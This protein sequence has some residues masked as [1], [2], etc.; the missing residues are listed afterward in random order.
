MGRD[1]AVGIQ[2]PG[3]ACGF[4]AYESIMSQFDVAGPIAAA[5]DPLAALRKVGDERARSFAWSLPVTLAACAVLTFIAAAAVSAWLATGAVVPWDSKN[6]FYAMYRFLGEALARGEVPLWNPF[7]FGGYPAVADP[8]SLIF[9]PTMF[10]FAA[11]FP[12]ASMQGFDAMIF[13]H[14]L[15]GGFGVLGLFRRRGWHPAGAVLAASIF[16][17]GGPAA[18]RLQHTGM[19]ISYGFIPVAFLLLEVALARC[20]LWA[21][22]GFG[23]VAALMAVGRDQVA[24]LACLTLI[25]L[26]VWQIAHDEAPLAYLRRRILLLIVMGVTGTALLAVPSI[27]TMQFLADSNRPGIAFGVA[28]AGSLPMSSA[29]STGPMIIGARATRRWSIRTGRIAP[30]ITSS[31]A[32]CPRCCFSGTASPADACSAAAFASSWRLAWPP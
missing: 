27:L 13:S 17:L 1:P 23:T 29:H 31:S 24:F 10:L 22:I 3:R 20:S 6:H 15:L 2:S 26:L 28:V 4:D 16:M 32:P 5:A 11:V 30:S 21:A 12:Q 19:I 25:A 8:Q 14:L 9:T 18:S 7:H